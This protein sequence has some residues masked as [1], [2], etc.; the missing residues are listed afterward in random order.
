MSDK[1]KPYAQTQY[2]GCS[3]VNFT[4]N[5]GWGSSASNCSVNLAGD[6]SSHW[7]STSINPMH[8]EL[9]NKNQQPGTTNDP[10]TSQS[11]AFNDEKLDKTDA[12]KS[13]FRNLIDKERNK[14][15]GLRQ[16]NAA[17]GDAKKR[18]TGK[19]CW[20]TIY[21]AG[22][23][24]PADWMDPD[25]GFIGNKN[26]YAG[27]ADL[28]IIGCPTFF[29][30]DNVWFGGMIKS[31][32]YSD[33]TY[34]V[35]L[36]S[37]TELLKGCK[38]IL[39]KYRGSVSTLIDN[40]GGAQQGG[41]LLAVPY[42]DTSIAADDPSKYKG[43]PLNG[44]IPNLF[45]VFGWLEASGFGNSGYTEEKGMPATVIYDTIHTF[46]SGQV[47]DLSGD[48]STMNFWHQPGS[49]SNTT[50]A[51][52]N[53]ATIYGPN[54]GQW[55]PYGA[56][57]AKTPVQRDKGSFLN[58][59][60][61]S[62]ATNTNRNGRATSNSA[63]IFFTEMGLVRTVKS[64]DGIERSLLRLDMSM[65][66]RPPAGA[67]INDDSMDILSFIEYCCD[68]AG[69][70][71]YLDFYPD[72][73]FSN[74]S[75]V[76]QVNTV[77]RRVQPLPN[78]IKNFILNL[79]ATDQVVEYN[80]GEEFNDTKSRS[81]LIGGPQQ[82]LYQANSNTVGH[83]KQRKIWEPAL[84]KWA[85]ANY[86]GPNS[87]NNS[88][89]NTYREPDTT[90]QRAFSDLG[91][92]NYKQN[93]GAV[94]AQ[95]HSKFFS[96]SDTGFNFSKFPRGSYFAPTFPNLGSHTQGSYPL[97]KDII[98][99]Y[100]GYGSNGEPRNTYYDRK[101]RQMQIVI[102][103]QDIAEVFPTPY[104]QSVN[105]DWSPIA[106][107]LASRLD[108][109]S[110]DLV[111]GGAL[112][113]TSLNVGYGKL[114][115]EENEIRAAMTT[116]ASPDMKKAYEDKG[117]LATWLGYTADKVTTG[118]GTAFSRLVYSYVSRNWSPNIAFCLLSG[119]G[120]ETLANALVLHQDFVHSALRAGAIPVPR[121][122]NR[123]RSFNSVNPAIQAEGLS[124]ILDKIHSFLANLGNT[125]YGKTY[126]VRIPNVGS[127][128]DGGK[129]NFTHEICDY[130]WEEPGNVID[131][132]MMVGTDTAAFFQEGG[133]ISPIL[134]FDNTG[135]KAFAPGLLNM[136]P[137][138]QSQ[139]MT[140]TGFGTLTSSS[141][142][143]YSPIATD[144]P[145]DTY[146][147]VPNQ[148]ITIGNINQINGIYT[149]GEINSLKSLSVAPQNSK[150]THDVVIPDFAQYKM[151][152]KAS[153]MA[154]NPANIYNP[155]IIYDNGQPK[156][157]MQAPGGM[158]IAG[159][160][161]SN[162]T[163]DGA[164]SVILSKANPF[165]GGANNLGQEAPAEVGG[166]PFDSIVIPGVN[167]AA[168]G[169]ALKYAY[170]SIMDAAAPFQARAA[171]PT[172][173]AIPIKYNLATYGPWS[174]HPGV[175]K[176]IVF[177]NMTMN[178]LNN[179]MINNLV[180]GVNVTMDQGLVPWEF[181]GIDALDIAA[182]LRVSESNEFQQVLE[183]GSLTLAGVML[184]NARVGSTLLGGG[185]HAPIVTS[186]SV[187][188]GDTIT[189][190]YELRTFSRKI[191]FYN[192]EAADNIKFFNQ[193]FIQAN[194]KIK[195][196]QSSAIQKATFVGNRLGGGY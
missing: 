104:A 147:N 69:C 131:N 98:S 179:T 196:A 144:A 149:N 189:T 105:A 166:G 171:V 187:T 180:G 92:Q 167:R 14:Y 37:F 19:K 48:G 125:Y 84:G 161:T 33:G 21:G 146:I 142:G 74:F 176:N 58:P 65:V 174:S 17:E 59:Y 55:S 12:S 145:E 136:G 153:V 122:A 16:E 182:L 169:L 2:L 108:K 45:N 170:A 9:E 163:Q 127:Y 156:V 10:V 68:N 78:T 64:T 126:G 83:M 109:V 88:F 66:P 54:H 114:V 141:H 95:K 44:N 188:I 61:T 72:N 185:S 53:S 184:N 23:S 193:K 4:M 11:Q 79:N 18:D 123:I 82:R 76:I 32:K 39:S 5:L 6:Y 40:T 113:G 73:T 112:P 71:F 137:Q 103:F 35:S 60:T 52:G 110:N 159:T 3:V 178:N 152:V 133:K 97:F 186:V 143:V 155:K 91:G 28:D 62:F 195:N 41:H 164:I 183:G 13:L 26:H 194:Q 158:F 107:V 181:G 111:G 140:D 121:S 191:G 49:F 85:N 162:D 132:T 148:P 118:V 77:T 165:Y 192:K 129:V 130:A 8:N 138:L 31:W 175:I 135:E 119:L 20:N 190:R 124:S 38:M 168:A 15:D 134:G 47:N 106:S 96:N 117:A 120:S 87:L 116:D 34:T 154:E 57:V 51:N 115:V 89:R 81:V 151:Y 177:P 27:K 80:F 43:T 29:R 50:L 70:D 24:V 1:V 30:F 157:V 128:F 139:S 173:A 56:I 63:E 42:N 36:S 22:S 102:D 100:F 150:S 90:I 25:P 7:N 46:L 160:N 67:Y 75:G 172:F 101:T 99:P 86:M 93:G 94:V